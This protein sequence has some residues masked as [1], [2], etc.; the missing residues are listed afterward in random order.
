MD[1]ARRNLAAEVRA[2][3]EGHRAT[4]DDRTR[5]ARIVSDT[6]PGLHWSVDVAPAAPGGPLVFRCAPIEEPAPELGHPLRWSRPGRLPC[7]HAALLARRLERL[8]LA[9]VDGRGLWVAT[10]R[11]LLVAVPSDADPFAGFA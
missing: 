1:D 7:K 3:T 2:V 10:D 11:P 4:F 5:T 9:R 6:T 8:G